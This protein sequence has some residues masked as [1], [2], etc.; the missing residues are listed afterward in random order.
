MN[1]LTHQQ[2]ITFRA[3]PHPEPGRGRKPSLR[4]LLGIIPILA[5]FFRFAHFL[6]EIENTVSYGYD[7]RAYC[8]D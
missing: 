7:R 5:L 3:L 8:K 4:L 1:E 2:Q 6:R